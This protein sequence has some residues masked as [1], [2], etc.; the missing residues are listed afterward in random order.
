MYLTVL[1]PLF[2]KVTF[3]QVQNH[4]FTDSTTICLCVFE[5]ELESGSDKE[6]SEVKHS[7]LLVSVMTAQWLARMFQ[8]EHFF[9][10]K[11]I[12]QASFLKFQMLLFST[13]EVLEQACKIR[14]SVQN[15]GIFSQHRSRKNYF[16]P[17][18]DWP[19]DSYSCV[20]YS[21]ERDGLTIKAV[22]MK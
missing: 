8:V 1:G 3:A 12:G 14:S 7:C 17:A 16:D 19:N 22:L 4:I 21:D 15:E 9:S 18:C 13:W 11:I 5:V 20:P 10:D 6:L 2:E